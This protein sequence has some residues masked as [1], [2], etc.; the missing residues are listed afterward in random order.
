MRAYFDYTTYRPLIRDQAALW[1]E[2]KPGWTLQRLAQHAGLQAPYLTNVLK[3]RAHLSPDQLHGV[4]QVFGW[5]QDVLDYATLLL[6][7]E[8]SAHPKR[9]ESL[10][11]K[12]DRIRREKLETKANLKAKAIETSSEE[13]SRFF[14]NPHHSLI[15][16]L[17]GIPRFARDPSRIARCLGIGPRKLQ[18]CLKALSEMNFIKGGPQ[19]YEKLRKNF[20]LPKES[21]IC[22]PHLNLMQQ[23][24]TQQLQRLPDEAKYGFSV[25]FSADP[26]TREKIQRE[27]L[28]FLQTIEPL[29]KT[30]PPEE[31]YGMRFDLFQWSHEGEAD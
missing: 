13:F 24:T 27:F 19:G 1:K 11:S 30:A 23:V 4:G 18:A 16:G 26:E 7:W 10:K 5:D 2:E 12:I 8:R 20:H 3:E 6:E 14:L 21:P 9:R 25:L 31:L 29:V 28:K 15:H 17:L 22:E